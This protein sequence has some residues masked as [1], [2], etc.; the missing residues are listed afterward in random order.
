MTKMKKKIPIDIKQLELSC[1]SLGSVQTIWK[2]V[3]IYSTKHV[4]L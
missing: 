2:T 4:F 3:S 1:T